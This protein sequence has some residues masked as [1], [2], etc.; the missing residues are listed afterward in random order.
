MTRVRRFRVDLIVSGCFRSKEKH[1]LIHVLCPYTYDV[2]YNKCSK[3]QSGDLFMYLEFGSLRIKGF[4]YSH[5]NQLEIKI[6]SSKVLGI[7]Q[8]GDEKFKQI[9]KPLS[10]I[11]CARSCI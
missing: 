11:V 7:F 3:C 6:L 1:L 8:K 9:V 4:F 10:R 5:W 2:Y